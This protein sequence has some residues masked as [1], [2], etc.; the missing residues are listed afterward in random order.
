MEL[1]LPP[2]FLSFYL[3]W[4]PVEFNQRCLLGCFP[5]SLAWSE[6]APCVFWD[7]VFHAPHSCLWLYFH[8]LFHDVPWALL[9]GGADIDA[10]F[11]VQYSTVPYSLYSDLLGVSI[12]WIDLAHYLC[13]SCSSHVATLKQPWPEE[14]PI[15]FLCICIFWVFHINAVI[16]Y[17]VS[18]RG[19]FHLAKH[20]M[21]QVSLYP[22]SRSKFYS[23][24]VDG[25]WS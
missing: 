4:W 24:P 10:P 8:I 3:F 9:G 12:D 13:Q 7:M 17:V 18:V 21:K 1:Q 11:R 25:H 19:F 14:P 16:H 22:L 15:H 23:L 2:N 20:W 5:I 6:R